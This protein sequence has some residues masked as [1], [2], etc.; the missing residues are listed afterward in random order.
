MMYLIWICV[1][2]S[3]RIAGYLCRV[4]ERSE[5]SKSDELKVRGKERR[6]SDIE[7]LLENGNA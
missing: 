1:T 5:I 7:H 3:R 6:L 4:L 2:L